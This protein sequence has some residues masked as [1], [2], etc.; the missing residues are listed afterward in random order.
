MSLTI[1][2]SLATILFSFAEAISVDLN[3]TSSVDLATSLV[4]D[5]LL[6]YYAGQHKGG[7]IGMFLPPAYWWEA[8]AAWNV[9]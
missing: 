6:N 9:R 4:A 8:G 2:I 7:T 3:D 5:G 1:F